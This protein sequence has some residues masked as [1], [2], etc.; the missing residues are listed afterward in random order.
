MSRPPLPC[1]EGLDLTRPLPELA[2]E[3]G[4]CTRTVARWRKE[5]GVSIPRGRTPE[6]AALGRTRLAILAAVGETRVRH[7]RRGET[8]Y[9]ARMLGVSKQAVSVAWANGVTD[10]TLAKWV[11]R[12]AV[13]RTV[14]GGPS[15]V[16]SGGGPSDSFC[17]GHK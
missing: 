4:V 5:A 11:A 7:L 9:A 15:L 1:P 6:P 8:S 10:E 12:C 3:A 2:E 17:A 13:N 16:D 14:L